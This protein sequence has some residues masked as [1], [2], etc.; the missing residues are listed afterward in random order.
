MLRM[1][2]ANGAVGFD[3]SYRDHQWPRVEAI[4]TSLL[5]QSVLEL[6]LQDLPLPLCREYDGFE[7]AI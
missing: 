1:E 4:C 2:L 7:C 5:G 3:E 6:P